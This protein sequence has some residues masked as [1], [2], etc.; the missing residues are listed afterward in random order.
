LRQ[1]WF[2]IAEVEK[3]MHLLEIDPSESTERSNMIKNRRNGKIPSII[4]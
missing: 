4:P 3:S 2:L 1:R